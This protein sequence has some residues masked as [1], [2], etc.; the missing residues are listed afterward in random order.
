MREKVRVGNR[1]ISPKKGFSFINPVPLCMY[2]VD[3]LI[4]VLTDK[5]IKDKYSNHDDL[6]FVYKDLTAY[7][8]RYMAKRMKELRKNILKRRLNET[9]R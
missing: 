3:M 7:L 6:G 8:K 5:H 4:T 9:N 1:L 2:D